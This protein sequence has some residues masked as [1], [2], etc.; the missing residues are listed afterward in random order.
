MTDNEILEAV[1]S[2]NPML[3]VG[4]GFSITPIIVACYRELESMRVSGD[5]SLEGW[6]DEQILDRVSDTI[7]QLYAGLI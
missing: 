4:D 5:L 2:M 3:L 1:S 7:G 6:T